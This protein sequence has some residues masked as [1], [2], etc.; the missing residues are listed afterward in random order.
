M[1][2]FK[3]G[4]SNYEEEYSLVDAQNKIIEEMKKDNRIISQDRANF[5][6]HRASETQRQ[7]NQLQNIIGGLP[8]L[9]QNLEA[10]AKKKESGKRYDEYKAEARNKQA[11]AEGAEEREAYEW[12]P[13]GPQL[14]SGETKKVSKEQEEAFYNAQITSYIQDKDTDPF[15]KTK[16]E[17][18]IADGVQ[19]K[20]I[21]KDT[22]RDSVRNA[23]MD[24]NKFATE[25]KAML[26]MENGDFRAADAA[27][28]NFIIEKMSTDSF[29]LLSRKNGIL[30][31]ETMEKNHRNYSQQASRTFIAKTNAR[32]KAARA[33][34]FLDD[35]DTNP[36]QAVNN[37]LYKHQAFDGKKDNARALYQLQTDLEFLEKQGLAT[38]ET[39]EKILNSKTLFQNKDTQ[40]KNI[41]NDFTRWLFGRKESLKTKFAQRQKVKSENELRSAVEQAEQEFEVQQNNPDIT[42]EALSEW[43]ND[44]LK[45]LYDNHL[46]LFITYDHPLFQGWKTGMYRLDGPEHSSTVD[47]LI[48]MSKR[49]APIDD[50]LYKQLPTY[51]KN[52]YHKAIGGN[53]GA[54]GSPSIGGI[55]KPIFKSMYSPI[56]DSKESLWYKYIAEN[57]GKTHIGKEGQPNSRLFTW[58]FKQGQDAWITKFN[59]L[60]PSQGSEKAAQQATTWIQ[61][62]YKEYK[63]NPIPSGY[64][65]IEQRTNHHRAGRRYIESAISSDAKL[66]LLDQKEFLPGEESYFKELVRWSV[67]VGDFPEY[68]RQIDLFKDLMPGEIGL[69]RLKILQSKEQ[70]DDLKESIDLKEKGVIL[71]NKVLEDM[72]LSTARLLTYDNTP[73]RTYRVGWE[74]LDDKG[75]F[76][77]I[78]TNDD[79]NS[80]TPINPFSDHVPEG[81]LSEMSLNDVLGEA[82][83]KRLNN[84][85]LYGL[86]PEDIVSVISVEEQQNG[87]LDTIFDEQLQGEL[88]RRIARIKANGSNRYGALVEDFNPL[89]NIIQQDFDELTS[90]FGPQDWFSIPPEQIKMLINGTE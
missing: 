29:S 46:G 65:N 85:G 6:K 34:D 89:P 14:G 71:Q 9:K 24:Y 21:Y 38:F 76:D 8:K 60:Y 15:T 10:A 82:G 79:P 83:K 84:L 4:A 81:N 54:E 11:F 67:G 45:D 1:D 44:K 51:Y 61:D 70:N 73:G 57:I 63:E 72:P 78:K 20:I 40:V 35:L 2:S 77:S 39:Y 62:R 30:Y 58:I 17:Q 32:Y 86:M 25:G 50:E 18:V 41:N 49:N 31:M 36:D 80:Y 3:F 33:S 69:R 52:Q 88:K 22:A 42:P 16:G 12:G 64:E 26:A 19:S 74:L 23:D 13:G 66:A 59:E 56:E 90:R 53:D 47:R 37:Y 87:F 27:L 75:F 28:K 5:A 55:N 68:Y 7:L 43:R 48:D